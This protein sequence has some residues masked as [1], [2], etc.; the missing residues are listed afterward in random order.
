MRD[1]LTAQGTQAM[2]SI[3]QP[4]PSF[5]L[6]LKQEPADGTPEPASSSSD[7]DADW[8]PEQS[9]HTPRPQRTAPDEA[10]L[11][12]REKNKAAQ[13]RWRQKYKVTTAGPCMATDNYH[14]ISVRNLTQQP[15]HGW[16]PRGGHVMM[17]DKQDEQQRKLERM[18]QQLIALEKEK[19]SVEAHADVLEKALMKLSMDNAQ[20]QVGHIPLWPLVW[21]LEAASLLPLCLLAKAESDYRRCCADKGDAHLHSRAWV[22]ELRPQGQ[23]RAVCHL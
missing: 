9:T 20:V 23:H 13:R 19:R 7:S 3:Y 15:S 6:P 22:D 2:C 1:L 11:R 4:P 14:R 5:L 8:E 16:T 21:Q 17:Q 12:V 10:K 18:Q